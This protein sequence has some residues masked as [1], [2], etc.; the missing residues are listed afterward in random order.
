MIIYLHVVLLLVG[1][2]SM[3][4]AILVIGVVVVV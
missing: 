3:D 1:G 4:D 2:V